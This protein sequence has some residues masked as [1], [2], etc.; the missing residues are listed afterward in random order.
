MYCKDTTVAARRLF[1]WRINFWFKLFQ[2]EIV[3]QICSTES[4]YIHDFFQLEPYHFHA[5]SVYDM[6]S[7]NW[8]ILKHQNVYDNLGNLKS[9]LDDCLFACN[10]YIHFIARKMVSLSQG[11]IVLCWLINPA[12][13]WFPL[14]VDCGN[15]DYWK[16]S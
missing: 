1:L 5:T 7:L 13:Q 16:Y 10:K 6:T 4:F 3:I 14:T 15:D 8:I 9:I 11:I 12:C 2:N